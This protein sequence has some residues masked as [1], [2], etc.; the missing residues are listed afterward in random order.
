MKQGSITWGAV[1]SVCH[2]RAHDQDGPQ[3]F[4]REWSQPHAGHHGGAPGMTALVC[5]WHEKLKVLCVDE[6]F[7]P[8]VQRFGSAVFQRLHQRLY[9]QDAR[10]QR[11]AECSRFLFFIKRL[12]LTF[13]VVPFLLLG[14]LHWQ[15][16]GQVHEV[17]ATRRHSLCWAQQWSPRCPDRVK[18]IHFLL[19]SMCY[20]LPCAIVKMPP[21]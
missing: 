20:H 18:L 9:R 10:Q 3:R 5:A 4:E 7:A 21:L 14:E 2:P 8:H 1:R 19:E 17:F 12:K 6:G 16:H 15:V 13:L 11:G